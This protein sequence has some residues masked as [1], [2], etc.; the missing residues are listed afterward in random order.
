M[1]L[2]AR[3]GINLGNAPSRQLT[4]IGGNILVREAGVDLQLLGQAD[5]AVVM[6]LSFAANVQTVSGNL[7]GL[8]VLAFFDFGLSHANRTI[9]LGVASSP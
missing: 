4:G 7:L 8:D 1:S 5:L 3:L 9:H 2:A 6:P